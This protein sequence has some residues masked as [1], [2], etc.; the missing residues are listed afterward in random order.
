MSSSE[1]EDENLKKFAEAVDVNLFNDNFYK[2][3]EEKCKEEEVK[4]EA[5]KSQ[6]HLDDEE[7]IFLIEI[8]VSESMKIH[9]AKKMSAVIEK[10][11]EFVDVKKRSLIDDDSCFNGVKLLKGFKECLIPDPEEVP[12]NLKKITIRR[13]KVEEMDEKESTKVQNV[14]TDITKIQRETSLWANKTRHSPY[15]FKTASDGKSHLQE[16]SSEFIKARNKNAWNESK[17]KCAKNYGMSLNK[18]ISK[19]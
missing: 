4:V 1:S 8:R 7:N 14:A 13:R 2:P 16:S 5:P 18:A 15:N 3:A 6:R 19:S 12:Q 9:I 17:I 10:E 11:I